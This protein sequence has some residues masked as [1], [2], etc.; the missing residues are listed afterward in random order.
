MGW[1]GLDLKLIAFNSK[2]HGHVFKSWFIYENNQNIGLKTLV[3]FEGD[4]DDTSWDTQYFNLDDCR[5][6]L[7]ELEELDYDSIFI[8]ITRNYSSIGKIILK[9]NDESITKGYK[10]IKFNKNCG[11]TKT[12]KISDIKTLS[13]N[14]SGNDT[15]SI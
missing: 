1:Q 10:R 9:L 12:Y 3:K 7:E 15:C 6:E 11:R 2:K 8:A 13:F 5:K 14:I 4:L